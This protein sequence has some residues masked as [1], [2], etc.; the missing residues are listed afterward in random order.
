MEDEDLTA[1][2]PQHS[3]GCFTSAKRI[4]FSAYV[5]DFEYLAVVRTELDS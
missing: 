2:K 5:A 1:K 4:T 3:C